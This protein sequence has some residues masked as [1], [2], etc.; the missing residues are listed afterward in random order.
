MIRQYFPLRCQRFCSL[1]VDSVTN[2]RKIAIRILC[3]FYA[4]VID[5]INKKIINLWMEKF[6]IGKEL[7]EECLGSCTLF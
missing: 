4:K 7:Q 2:D 3:V 1:F 5:I 6:L